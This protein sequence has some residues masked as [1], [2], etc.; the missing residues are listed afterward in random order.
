MV[1]RGYDARPAPIVTP[2]PS[3]NEAKNEPWRAPTRTT[4]SAVYVR[5]TIAHIDTIK[6]T[7][8]VVDT[9][10]ETTVDNNTDNRGDEATVETRNTIGSEGLL[11]DIDETVEL[12]GSSAL[13]RLRVVGKTGTR[14]VKRVHEEERRG[15]SSTTGGDVARE[16]HP[17]AILLLEAEERL[18]VVLCCR[19]L[20][21]CA[22]ITIFGRL[23]TEGKVQ[24]LRGEVPDDVGS[25][26]SPEGENALVTSGTREAVTNALVGLSKTTLLDLLQGEIR[27]ALCI[28]RRHVTN[29]L[30]L[31]L[32]EQLDTLNGGGGGLGNSLQ[33]TMTPQTGRENRLA[34]KT[35]RRHTTHHEVDYIR[36]PGQQSILHIEPASG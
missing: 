13:G 7:E 36:V 15:T 33:E 1:S 21:L 22:G 28:L 17:V 9:E 30:V 31:V 4:G 19:P 6:L 27:D 25:V 10:V 34:R 5:L 18:E 23:R 3:K 8:G 14:V 32:D 12:A 20:A 29:H 11:V 35:Y 26:T 16:P 2:Q 24:R